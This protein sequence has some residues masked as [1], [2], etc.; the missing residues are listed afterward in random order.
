MATALLPA[1]FKQPSPTVRPF[2]PQGDVAPPPDDAQLFVDPVAMSG[3]TPKPMSTESEDILNLSTNAAQPLDDAPSAEREP[4]LA[5]LKPE[6]P[7]KKKRNW[8]LIGGIAAMAVAAMAGGAYW[9]MS[10]KGYKPLAEASKD[11][12]QPIENAVGAVKEGMDE[13]VGETKK[14]VTDAVAEAEKA[15]AKPADKDLEQPIKNAVDAVKEGMDEVVGETK[16]AVTEAAPEVK[17]AVAKPADKSELPSVPPKKNRRK[18]VDK[19]TKWVQAKITDNPLSSATLATMV[20]FLG[21]AVM[22]GALTHEQALLA[23]QHLLVQA[24][25]LGQHLPHLSL[26]DIPTALSHASE[27]IT[28]TA[29][30]LIHVGREKLA[31]VIDPTPPPPPAPESSLVPYR[32]LHQVG[33]SFNQAVD[34]LNQN[35]KRS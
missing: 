14:A 30:D 1:L 3:D 21:V 28:H 23:Y 22:S 8:P 15:V 10:G 12:E 9:L 24:H 18:A 16:K 31:Q 2:N 7:P 29:G 11:L 26:P 4:D 20:S 32:P 5:T 25:S 34:W 27:S 35:L 6:G 17:E 19:A 13:V 33:D